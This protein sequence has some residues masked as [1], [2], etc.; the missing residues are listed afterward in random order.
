MSFLL[1]PPIAFVLY[2][3]LVGVLSGLG[4]L[5][6][7][8][9]SPSP[10]KSSSYTGGESLP[11]RLGLPG[12]RPF[13]VIALFFAVLHLGVLMLGSSIPSPISVLYLAGLILA[14]IALVLG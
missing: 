12:Y 3:L 13:F 14:L 4:K 7:G 9:E 1:I 10:E 6:A 8:P 5:L 2:I 11:T